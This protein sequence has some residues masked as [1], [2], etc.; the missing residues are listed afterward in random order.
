MTGPMVASVSRLLVGSL[1]AVSVG[2]LC[3]CSKQGVAVLE[4]A[5]AE[6]ADRS[7][8][9]TSLPKECQAYVRQVEAWLDQSMESAESRRLNLALQHQLSKWTANQDP[10]SLLAD[11]KSA[12]EFFDAVPPRPCAKR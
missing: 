1:L 12:N 10:A 2:L 6:E 11:C 7:S 9:T 3:G 4:M 8:P 5:M